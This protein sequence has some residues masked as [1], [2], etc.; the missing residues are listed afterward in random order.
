MHMYL[1][2][3]LAILSFFKQ[4]NRI[5]LTFIWDRWNKQSWWVSYSFSISFQT[6][7]DS[8]NWIFIQLDT[9]FLVNPKKSWD[10]RNIHLRKLFYSYNTQ[11]TPVTGIL[12][13]HYKNLRCKTNIP[14]P[15]AYTIGPQI[16]L[17]ECL[18]DCGFQGA[19]LGTGLEHLERQ[20]SRAPWLSPALWPS[21]PQGCPGTQCSSQ[22]VLQVKCLASSAAC[23]A[24]RGPG[25]PTLTS[26]R[27]FTQNEEEGLHLFMDNK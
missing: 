9:Q 17:C 18:L 1:K 2:V 10:F 12:V 13:S 15:F 8:S 16:L 4:T 19:T 11:T 24:E 27:N 21:T 7:N 5:M 25:L 14:C 22:M 20:Q 6:N 3:F 26:E 23:P